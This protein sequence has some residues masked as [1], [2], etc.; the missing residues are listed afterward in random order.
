MSQFYQDDIFF[1]ND[2]SPAWWLSPDIW[3]NGTAAG[4]PKAPPGPGE[5]TAD[6]TSLFV[7]VHRNPPDT[8][9]NCQLDVY[10]G[11]PSLV[12]TPAA[13]T[14]PLPSQF[15]AAGN[16]TNDV[17]VVPVP[18]TPKP[19][20]MDPNDPQGVGHR[21]VIARAYRFDDPAPNTFQVPVEPHE[22]QLNIQIVS[23]AK[24]GPN[25]AGAG[26]GMAGT[27]AGEPIGPTEDG[28]WEFRIDTTLPA[29]AE[30]ERVRIAVTAPDPKEFLR[31]IPKDRRPCRSFDGFAKPTRRFSLDFDLPDE[32]LPT[33]RGGK[34]PFRPKV[35]QM[36]FDER[37]SRAK[38]DVELAAKQV[39][40]FGLKADLN[41]T[42]PGQAQ[43]FALEQTD[44]KGRSQGGLTVI[45]YRA[46]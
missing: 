2:G 10:I 32:D 6:T 20:P 44:A 4:P 41:D 8:T 40:R 1:I 13:G 14:F 36:A 25:F 18:W 29:E 11:N 3:I 24:A 23:V 37:R 35:G 28:L 38:V 46:E 19:N 30:S 26:T 33:V 21:C 5:A 27:D 42:P 15:V 9:T 22:A 31:A 12:M 17:S 45:F 34:R 7:R 43:I 16:F 39:A